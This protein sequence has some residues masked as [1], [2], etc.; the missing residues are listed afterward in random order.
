MKSTHFIIG[1]I[2]FTLPLLGFQCQKYDLENKRFKGQLAIA[3][4]CSSYTITLLEG[5]LPEGDIQTIWTDPN[6]GIQYK[7]VFRLEN[8]CQFPANIKQGDTFYFTIENNP[9]SNCM[10]CMAYY[11]T[12][13]V[14]VSIR[15]IEP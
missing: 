9:D 15:V 14:G 8:P 2:L 13:D 6:T 7:N 1:C 4:I 10:I 12:P 3:G 11:P 5:E